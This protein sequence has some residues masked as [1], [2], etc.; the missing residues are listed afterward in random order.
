MSSAHRLKTAPR[1]LIPLTEFNITTSPHIMELYDLLL[2]A[3]FQK[4]EN[5]LIHCTSSLCR[6]TFLSTAQPKT[7]TV[8]PIQEDGR[9]SRG[10][11]LSKEGKPNATEK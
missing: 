4:T 10:T 2:S 9:A 11:F 1:D 6:L 3:L 5:H 7:V 8:R